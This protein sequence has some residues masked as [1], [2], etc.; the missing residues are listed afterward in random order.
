[1]PL[2][3]GISIRT[4]WKIYSTFSTTD[5]GEY[6][7]NDIDKVATQMISRTNPYV[8]KKGEGGIDS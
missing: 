5:M 7:I 6:K 8:E 1:M 3:R 2:E 4:D